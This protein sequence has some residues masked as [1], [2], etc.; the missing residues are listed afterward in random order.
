MANPPQFRISNKCCDW[1]KKNIAKGYKKENNIDLNVIGLRRAEGGA[2]QL[3]YK[4]C[5][6]QKENGISEYRPIWWYTDED[7]KSYEDACGIIHS[8]CYTKYGLTRTGC[9]GCPFGRNFEEELAII[10]EHEPKLFKAV[11]NIFKNSYDY[12]RKYREFVKMMNAK[13]RGVKS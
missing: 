8:E 3:R 1:A 12:T 2:R 10:E 9:S 4:N 7:K 11:N 6:D 13:T 5:F